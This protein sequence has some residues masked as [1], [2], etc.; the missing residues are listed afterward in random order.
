MSPEELHQPNPGLVMLRISATAR[1]ALPRSA[2]L[3]RDWRGGWPAP[4]DGRARPRAGAW[5]VDWR[6]AGGPARHHR[7]AHGAVPPQVNGGKGQVIDVAL[8]EAVFNV[9]ESL[10]PE[11]S[12]FGAVREA[13]GS[14]LPGIAP[15]NAYPCTTAGCWWRQWRQHLQAPDGRDWSGPTW[16][17]RPTWPTTPAAWRVWKKSTRHWRLERAAHRAAGAGRAGAARVP[18]GKVY[19]AKDIAEDP[20]HRA[21]D[22]L[23]TQRRAMATAWKCRASCP[24]LG[25][26]GHH[27]QQ[28]RTWAMT[29]MP[30]WQKW[31]SMPNRLRCCAA[32]QS[33]NER[34]QHRLA[35]R[36]P[37]H[38]HA[39]GRPARW[40]ADGEGLR[41]LKTRSRCAMRCRQ[42][43]CPRSK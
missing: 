22:M 25:H 32:K 42:R 5:G 43:V 39:G 40:P 9:M 19:T 12:A 24:S 37:P 33:C 8:H 18:A 13:A 35:R 26:A 21:R 15:S 29:P 6:H 38:P 27:P 23:L 30:C 16:A 1:R 2:G 31:G 10:I 11:Y 17:Q 14:A 41:P 20:H 28:R 34:T 3:W 7:R 36:R 4:P